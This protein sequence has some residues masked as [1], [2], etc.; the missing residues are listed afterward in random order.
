[1]GDKMELIKSVNGINIKVIIF[2]FDG[3]ISTLRQG[4]EGIMRPFMIEM[5]SG[6]REP[7]SEVIQ[8]VDQ[9][10]E[11][12]TGIQTIFQMKW[13]VKKVREYGFNHE[14]YGPWNYKAEY[15]RRLLNMVN[16]RLKSLATGKMKK[17]D[18]LIKGS[19]TFLKKLKE[20]GYELYLTSGTDHP[21]VLNEANLL[22]VKDYFDKIVGAPLNRA[23][24]SKKAVI[25]HL[26]E[27]RGILG[28]EL[29]VIG[30]GRVEIALGVEKGAVTLGMATD[31]INR[32][33]IN[34]WKRKRL[35]KAGAHA[36]AGD[37]KNHQEIFEWLK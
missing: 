17:E 22:G 3:T 34:Y 18:F 8:E 15:N 21:D 9:Y 13:L 10:I 35:L 2:D 4:W 12:S 19:L 7:V 5:I 25:N 11:D 23:D 20:K 24:S 30:D 28:S 36:I 6:A 33:G 26:I 31:E 1:M 27:K 14:I 37:F 16:S 29:L 32:E